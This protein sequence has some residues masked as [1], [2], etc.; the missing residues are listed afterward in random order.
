LIWQPSGQFGMAIN[1]ANQ[2][3]MTWQQAPNIV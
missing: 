2:E 3:D 1:Q